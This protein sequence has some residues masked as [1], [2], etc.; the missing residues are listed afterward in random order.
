MVATHRPLRLI[1]VT[2]AETCG[3][4]LRGLLP[5]D[6]VVAF[7]RLDDALRHLAHADVDC[8][9]LDLELPEAPG[10]EGVERVLE[11]CGAVPIV[12]LTGRTDD[13]LAIRLIRA[14][15]QDFVPRNAADGDTL[16][17]AIRTA[18]ERH[19]TGER[20]EVERM[21]REVASE[22]RAM[23]APR[24]SRLPLLG[25]LALAVAFFVQL[26]WLQHL[27]GIVLW[28]LFAAAAVIAWRAWGRGQDGAR[29][30][31]SIVEGSADG[32]FVKDLEGRYQLVNAA[33][34]RLLGIDRGAVIGHTDDELF[35]S[36]AS[37]ARR[38]RDQAVLATG[39]TR[40]YWRTITVGDVDRTVSVVKTPFRDRSGAIVGLIGTVRDETAIRRLEE[41]TTR[42]FDLAPDMLC[43]AGANGRLE[44]VNDAWTGVLGW[45]PEEL[46]SRPLIDFVHPDDRVRAGRE[47]EQMF[48]GVIDG[49]TNRLATRAGGWRDVE[50][51]ARVVAEDERIYAVARDV[52]E[53]NR[54]EGALEA[55]EARYRT[56]V[57]N[58]PNSSVVTY[59][60][61]LRYTFAAGDALATAGLSPDILGRTLSE[62]LPQHAAT[63][64]PRYRAA[65][66]GHSQAFEFSGATGQYWVQIAPL[67]DGDGVIEGGML[68][69]QDI[70]AIKQAERELA[71]VDELFKTA[72][73]EAPIGMG[74]VDP[75]TG[76]HLRVNQALCQITG[77]TEEQL[78]GMTADDM[79]HP[80]DV[81][82]TAEARRLLLDGAGIHRNEKRYMHADGHI[83]WVSVNA[84]LVRD[85]DGRPLHSSPRSRTS[86]SAAASRN[87]LQH[88]ADHDP[89]TGL[90]NRRRFE[91][92]LDRHVAHAQRYGAERRAARARPR[93]L[94]VRQRHAR[95]QRRRRADRRGRAALLRGALRDTDVV[96]R[97]GGDEF[98]VLL[99]TGGTE[100]G[101]GGRRRARS[102]RVRDEIAVVG[103]AAA[104]R[105]ITA[106]VGVALFDARPT[107]PARTC[108]STPTSR[109]TT[110]RRPA[111]TASP[112]TPPTERPPGA[113]RRRA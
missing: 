87:A 103:S 23:P 31:E 110:P 44:R 90:L 63:L 38:A 34:A 12:A 6:E 61:D 54:M 102:T 21:V 14:G 95:P 11:A 113:D 20:R 68:L 60:H 39:E 86:P 105:R 8:V 96:A 107:R 48:S 84:T 94:Q 40:R 47:I 18:V 66:G 46:R 32:V 56:L 74:L 76:R 49:C 112:S 7:E 78:L 73:E 16:T 98:A 81:A 30:L 15:A 37:A 51:T 75:Q 55:S 24:R 17:R 71:E 43:T 101:R 109:C 3:A 64:V 1:L 36:D 69:T 58:L 13:A 45:T 83:V 79:T 92:E 65:L 42:F 50:W 33:A 100:R 41:E 108:S 28:A 82:G 59:D 111:A 67:R 77:Y 57:H 97:L 89:L 9:L 106:S 35:G 99:P 25:C 22:V 91:Q 104:P 72:F 26:A 53:R 80:D 93:Q 4:R 10:T 62:V 29:L 85:A 27:G 19:R 52:T 5:D 70:T 2:H 88:M